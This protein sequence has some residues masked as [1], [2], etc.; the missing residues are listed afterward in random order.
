[1]TTWIDGAGQPT[2]KPLQLADLGDGFKLIYCFQH[3][4]PGCHSHGFPTLQMLVRAL[5]GK[6]FGFAV[7][8][9][10]F[11]GFEENTVDRLRPTQERYGLAIPFGHDVQPAGAGLS[12]FMLDYQTGG[13]P[14]FTVIDPQ[15]RVIYADFNLDPARFLAALGQDVPDGQWA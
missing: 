7:I 2:K 1:M 13:T 4:C 9:T 14:W 3:W 6:G 15:G 11:E 8:Q 5:A 12:G 10:V